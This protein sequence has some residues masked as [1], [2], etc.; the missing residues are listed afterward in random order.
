MTICVNTLPTLCTTVN[1]TFNI[2]LSY[3]Y[4]TMSAGTNLQRI[5]VNLLMLIFW[6]SDGHQL[7]TKFLVSHTCS[8]IQNCHVQEDCADT[9]WV[10]KDNWQWS[11]LQSFLY[12]HNNPNMPRNVT[13]WYKFALRQRKPLDS[14]LEVLILND[15]HIKS[16]HLI[17]INKILC[18]INFLTAIP[19]PFFGF[20]DSV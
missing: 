17:A 12:R 10:N 19:L 14:L 3:N 15:N 8:S 13:I 4:T 2:H 1:H 20:Q 16:T 11:A 5:G 6:R 7:K 9:I 18:E